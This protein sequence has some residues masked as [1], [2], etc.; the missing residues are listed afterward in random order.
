MSDSPK[1]F[2]TQTFEQMLRETLVEYRQV[3]PYRS[4]LLFNGVEHLHATVRFRR[5]QHAGAGFIG[6]FEL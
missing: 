5:D 3:I 1:Q 4:D 2:N 6:K